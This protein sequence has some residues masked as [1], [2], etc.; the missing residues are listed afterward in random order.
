MK[1]LYLDCFSGISGDMAVGALV[2]AGADFEAIRAALDSLRV[3]DFTV[4]AARVKKKG[5]M[6]TRFQVHIDEAAKQPHRHLRHVVEIIARGDLPEAVKRAAIATFEIIA[7]AEAEVHG[8]DKEKVHFHEV[9]AIDSIV[10]IVAAQHAKHLLGIEAVYVSPLHL[11]SGAVKCAHGV[12]P[13]P[14]PATALILRGKPVYGG[15]VAG[16]LVT[17]TGA[18]LAVQWAGAFG[19]MPEMT[20]ETIGHGSGARDLPDRANVLRVQIGEAAGAALA[21]GG[22]PNLETIT[23]LEAN[24]DDMTGELFPPLLEALLEAGARD[25]FVTSILGKKGRPAH[26]I[27]VLCDEA[28][29][30]NAADALF[31][32]STT[33]GVRMRQERRAVLERSWETVSTPWGAVRVKIGHYDGARNSAAPEYE[34][35]K[36]VAGVAGVAVRNVYDA[37]LAALARGKEQAHGETRGD[38]S[39]QL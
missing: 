30:R 15:E 7:E 36:Q 25:A 4:S 1:T 34:D 16:E 20:V 24:V 10:D 11:G 21:G 8:T 17:P 13:V 5:L 23:V 19:P 33:L 3:P 29:T 26:C 9:G 31:K 37:A 6:A 22:L 2:D 39:R 27:T 14:A 12:M 18:A 28:K 38:I 35:C 32:N